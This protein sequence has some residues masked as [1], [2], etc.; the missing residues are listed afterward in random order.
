MTLSARARRLRGLPSLYQGDEG[1]LASA[2]GT[3]RV[4]VCQLMGKNC[5]HIMGKCQQNKIY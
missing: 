1:R 2:F 3:I 5:A 4:M